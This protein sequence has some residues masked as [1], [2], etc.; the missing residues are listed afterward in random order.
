MKEPKTGGSHIWHQDY[1]FVHALMQ[2]NPKLA[3]LILWTCKQQIAL[4]FKVCPRV[5]IV[6]LQMSSYCAIRNERSTSHL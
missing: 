4:K 5:L 2:L 1:G 3:M 6:L